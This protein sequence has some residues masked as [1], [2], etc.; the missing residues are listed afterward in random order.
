MWG[1]GDGQ[2]IE[3]I[4]AGRHREGILTPMYCPIPV[5]RHKC[6]LHCSTD[7]K[8]RWYRLVCASHKTILAV[9]HECAVGTDVRVFMGPKP[10]A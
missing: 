10:A 2:Q 4:H 9:L 3:K 8:K 6:T 5:Y 7:V 1:A